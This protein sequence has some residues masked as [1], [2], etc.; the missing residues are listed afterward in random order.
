MRFYV[1]TAVALNITVP[2]DVVPCSLVDKYQ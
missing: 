1:L 2:C